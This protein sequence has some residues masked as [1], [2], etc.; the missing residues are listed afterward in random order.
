MRLWLTAVH[1]YRQQGLIECGDGDGE[2]PE[3]A[4]VVGNPN[5]M[6]I[7]ACEGQGPHVGQGAAVLEDADDNL[8]GEGSDAARRR[9]HG[10]SA[11]TAG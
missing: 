7:A 6:G 10:A 3:N 1:T 9:G 8:G 11:R 2:G 5:G 4:G